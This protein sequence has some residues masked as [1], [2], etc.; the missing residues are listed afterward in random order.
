MLTVGGPNEEK[1]PWIDSCHSR[2]VE[3]LRDGYETDINEVEPGVGVGLDEFLRAANVL[4]CQR[5][6]LESAVYEV[7]Q[8]TRDGWYSTCP[9]RQIG[10]PTRTTSGTIA[11]AASVST[12]VATA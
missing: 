12:A 5:L 6:S 11:V 2:N 9:T 10:D 4:H 3:P 7:S 1:I 8:K